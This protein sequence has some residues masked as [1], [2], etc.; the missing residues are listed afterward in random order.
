MSEQT[1]INNNLPP[2]FK[3]LASDFGSDQT[4]FKGVN[5]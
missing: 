1:S 3:G 2:G 4:A 5:W